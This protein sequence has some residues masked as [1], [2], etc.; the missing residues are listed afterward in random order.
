[1]NLPLLQKHS[2]R[3]SARLLLA[4]G[5]VATPC[6]GQVGDVLSIKDAKQLSE[7]IAALQASLSE[8]VLV[9]VESQIG[10]LG[11]SRIVGGIP[12]PDGEYPDCAAV[13]SD[14]GQ[15]FCSGVLISPDLV[16]TARHCVPGVGKV[17]LRGSSLLK[18]S[19]GEYATVVEEVPH[20]T[21]DVALLKLSSASQVVPRR[22][23]RPCELPAQVAEATAVGFGTTNLGGTVGYGTKR[24]VDLPV[25]DLECARPAETGCRAGTEMVA[26]LRALDKDSC[27]GDSGGPLYIEI[28]GQPLLLG[29]TSRGVK[30]DSRPCGDGGVYVRAD[31]LISWIEARSGETLAAGVCN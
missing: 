25:S 10:G 11:Y 5:I 8:S 6:L 28:G 26:G 9:T 15:F 7:A 29:L 21:E 3:A 24:Q 1:M 13:G 27:S 23:A 12:T 17:F 18:S 20:P 16:L 31:R 30:S 22:I 14:D 19:T 4:M 2:S